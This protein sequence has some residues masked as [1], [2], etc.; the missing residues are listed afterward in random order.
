MRTKFYTLALIGFLSFSIGASAEE[1]GTSAPVKKEKMVKKKRVIRNK[2]AA[3]K[4]VP[5]GTAVATPAPKQENKSAT[6]WIR[7]LKKKLAKSQARQNQIV[8]VAA[9]RG[10]ETP[11]SPPLYWKGK[12]AA[13]DVASHE[14]SEFDLALDTA[15]KGDS[16]GSVQAL[17][18]F[19]GKYPQSPLA[20]EAKDVIAKLQMPTESEPTQQ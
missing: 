10:D 14:V 6:N 20:E 1:P 8:A 9:V 16:V 4:S 11:D 7:E 3:K 18:T 13:G 12:K 19:V 5:L 17:E 2:T 15:L